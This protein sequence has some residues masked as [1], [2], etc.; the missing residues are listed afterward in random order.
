MPI[1]HRW[2]SSR[3][4]VTYLTFLLIETTRHQGQASYPQYCRPLIKDS[5]ENFAPSPIPI[6]RLSPSKIGSTLRVPHTA[7]RP[8]DD[9]D[10]GLQPSPKLSQSYSLHGSIHKIQFVYAA[11]PRVETSIFS[12]RPSMRIPAQ[13]GS[14]L[15]C[16]EWPNPAEETFTLLRALWGNLSVPLW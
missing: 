10:F 6:A 15:P 12:P 11:I 14:R 4:P 16:L 5:R 1:T 7:A 13:V 9:P 3:P 8:C 2:T